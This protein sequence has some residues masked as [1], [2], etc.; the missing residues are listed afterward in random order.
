MHDDGPCDGGSHIKSCSTYPQ[1][2]EWTMVE[3][4]TDERQ[5][6]KNLFCW[7]KI[8]FHSF[9]REI[10]EKRGL[11]VNNIVILEEK[12]TIKRNYAKFSRIDKNFKRISEQ[13]LIHFWAKVSIP[14]FVLEISEIT[15]Y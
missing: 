10:S 1:R 7:L 15:S 6:H 8:F 2:D 11:S 3:D 14:E 4:W 9:Y 13:F 5:K 12:K